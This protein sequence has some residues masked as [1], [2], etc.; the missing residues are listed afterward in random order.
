MAGALGA[1]GDLLS[2]PLLPTAQIVNPVRLYVQS[3][4]HRLG[5]ASAFATVLTGV[6]V[7]GSE[8]AWDSHTPIS[9][10]PVL[11]ETLG[12]SANP[13]TEA[14]RAVL[15]AARRDADS[16]SLTEVGEVR[17]MTTSGS[18]EPPAQTLTVWRGLQPG[19]G[20]SGQARRLPVQ[21]PSPGPAAGVPYATPFAWGRC[22]LVLPRYPGT[23]VVVTHQ[24]GRRDDAIDVGAVWESGHGPDSQAGDWWLSLPVGVPEQQ[25]STLADDAVPAEHTGAVTNDLTDA[26]GNRVIE[27]G[28]LTVRVGRDTLGKAGTR[29]PRG[30]ED[31]VTIEHSSGA[32][33]VMKQD[34]TVL[35]EAA[36][37]L[38]LKAGGDI[39][40]EATNVKVSVAGSMDVS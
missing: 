11:T 39:K 7:T 10:S 31:G 27:V 14:A 40:L 15:R 38:E 28:E 8:D 6:E 22:G 36:K 3:V 4:Q 9:G 32:K 20:R 21:R 24:G 16:A 18:A 37:N 12:A 30:E 34:G 2:S 23:R 25:R 19:D 1:L 35:I 5:R 33:I 13:E 29:P 17:S 26:D